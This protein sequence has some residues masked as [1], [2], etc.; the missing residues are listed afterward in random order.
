MADQR[1]RLR[2]PRFLPTQDNEKAHKQEELEN[3]E[4]KALPK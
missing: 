2:G 1:F 3:A 4:K